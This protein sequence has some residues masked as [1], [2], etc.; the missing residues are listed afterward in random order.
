MDEKDWRNHPYWGEVT[1]RAYNVISNATGSYYGTPP[2]W[3][4]EQLCDFTADDI[5]RWPGAGRKVVAEIE[6]LLA[7]HG[8][9]LKR[10]V[11]IK[12]AP[13]RRSG[14]PDDI[15]QGIWDAALSTF[16]KICVRNSDGRVI[17][18]RAL[19]AELEACADIADS[20]SASTASAPVVATNIAAAI[21]NRT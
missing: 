4:V 8:K 21:R 16:D 1:T 13:V 12:S 11:P 9:Q 7:D 6:A 15:P 14:K 18:A 20:Q 2:T 17:I 5:L 10:S 3:T 19:M